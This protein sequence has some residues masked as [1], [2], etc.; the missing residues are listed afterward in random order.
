MHL[1]D[2]LRQIQ[3]NCGNLHCGRLP[4]TRGP[5]AAG[6]TLMPGAGPSTP[7]SI[8]VVG[9]RASSRSASRGHRAT[10]A[11]P[12]QAGPGRWTRPPATGRALSPPSRPRR[13]R[14]ISQGHHAGAA[15]HHRGAARRIS[16]L[17]ENLMSRHPDTAGS[18]PLAPAKNHCE[19]SACTCSKTRSGST[20]QE[21]LMRRHD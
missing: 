17:A 9:L 4:R 13:P 12:Q 21:R 14:P 3:T 11:R 5:I 6:G 1:E 16:K 15:V 19:P 10:P 2:I 8:L 7:S 20:E 18:N